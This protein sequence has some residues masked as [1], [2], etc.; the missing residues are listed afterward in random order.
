M[1]VLDYMA[2]NFFETLF[3]IIS[4]QGNIFVF[5]IY[6]NGRHLGFVGFVYDILN[7]VTTLD[8]FIS[9]HN[10]IN[11]VIGNQI[12]YFCLCKIISAVANLIV[13]SINEH[14]TIVNL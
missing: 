12:K 7:G 2:D 6:D 4:N 10:N 5:S 9:N 1:M 13:Y 11:F 14:A 3:I 8:F